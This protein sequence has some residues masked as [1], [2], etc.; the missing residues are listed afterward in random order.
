M[1]DGESPFW[2]SRQCYVAAVV[3]CEELVDELVHMCQL[4]HCTV[5]VKVE[6][7]FKV[8]HKVKVKV[9]VNCRVDDGVKVEARGSSNISIRGISPE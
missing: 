3:F 4:V 5:K 7:N 1:W 2:Y 8:N 6:I 9:K